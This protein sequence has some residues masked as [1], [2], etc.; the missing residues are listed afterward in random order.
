MTTITLV[1]GSDGALRSCRA[2]GHAGF[3]AKGYDIVCAAVTILMRTALQTLSETEGVV[4][5]TDATERGVISFE[6]VQA[7]EEKTERLVCMSEFLEH[8][9]CSLQS[10]YPQFVELQKQI[11]T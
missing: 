11:G 1:C 6:V 4:I 10:E 5:H 2:E 8:G 7:A 3:A 9:F